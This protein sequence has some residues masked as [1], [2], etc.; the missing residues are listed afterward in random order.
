VA[1]LCGHA[2]TDARG[3]FIIQVGLT[4]GRLHERSGGVTGTDA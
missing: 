4:L 2:P 1:E 3:A